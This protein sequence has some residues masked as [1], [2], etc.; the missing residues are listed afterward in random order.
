MVAGALLQLHSLGISAGLT[1]PR[2]AR[3]KFPS[4]G[5]ITLPVRRLIREGRWK[6]WEKKNVPLELTHPSAP[7]FDLG[8]FG[9]HQLRTYGNC[10]PS[11]MRDLAKR[12]AADSV[13]KVPQ[14]AES[15]TEGTLKQF[16]KR[17]A[18]RTP[19]TLFFFTIIEPLFTLP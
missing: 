18:T 8:F 3:C 7:R 9:R 11:S 13:V 16:S 2:P 17:M 10:S 19:L 15:I 14:M 4:L 1:G 5:K 6:W 12:S